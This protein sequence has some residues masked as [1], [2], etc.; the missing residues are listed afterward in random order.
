[1]AIHCELTIRRA[2]LPAAIMGDSKGGT[3][4]PWPRPK[5]LKPWFGPLQT[6]EYFN[7]MSMALHG[8]NLLLWAVWPRLKHHLAPRNIIWPHR[9]HSVRSAL[10]GNAFRDHNIAN[11][12]VKSPF[13]PSRVHIVWALRLKFRSTWGHR[14]YYQHITRNPQR[15]GKP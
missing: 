1:M 15:Y 14:F 13:R 5:A 4:G 10:P 6:V 7:I 12:I 11:S 3:T 8:K 9:K 2:D